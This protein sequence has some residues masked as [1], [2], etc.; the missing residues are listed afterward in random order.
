MCDVTVILK[1]KEVRTM[2]WIEKRKDKYRVRYYVYENGGNLPS[3]CI[4]SVLTFCG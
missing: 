2:A 3:D 1:K 4:F